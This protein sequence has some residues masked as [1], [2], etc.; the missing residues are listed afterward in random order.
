MT[1]NDFFRLYPVTAKGFGKMIG[2]TPKQMYNILHRHTVLPD[3]EINLFNQA[4]QALSWQ[5]SKTYVHC[6]LSYQAK[7]RFCRKKFTARD[8]GER[9]AIYNYHGLVCDKCIKTLPP[10]SEAD[11]V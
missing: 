2:Y 10:V 5:L 8:Y 3:E 9:S 1:I 4:V 11:I 6:D 7:C